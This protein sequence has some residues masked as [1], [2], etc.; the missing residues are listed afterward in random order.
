MYFVLVSFIFI[1]HSMRKAEEEMRHFQLRYN[2][3]TAKTLMMLT[4]Q[5][6]FKTMTQEESLKLEEMYQE[7]HELAVMALEDYET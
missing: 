4:E 1:V 6:N 7:V 2:V 3:E 5:I